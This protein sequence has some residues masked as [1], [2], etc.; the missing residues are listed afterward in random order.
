M[1]V[2]D[3]D[4]E[5]PEE[6][7]AQEPVEPRDHSRL[8][9]VDRKSG[10]ITD[11]HFWEIDKWLFPGDVLVVNDTRVVPAR[12]YGKLATGG[13]V[14]FLLLRQVVLGIWETLARPARKVKP[15]I[16][17]Y[18][19]EYYADVL[20][21]KEEGIRLVQ[22]EPKDIAPLLEARGTVALP[23]YI[24]KSGINPQRYQTVYARKSGAVAAPTAGLHFTPELLKKVCDKGVE[25]VA[26]TLHAGLG[27]FRPVK[28]ERVEEHRMYSEEFE[29]SPASTAVLNRALK[30]KRRVVCVGTTTVRVLE[31]QA[32]RRGE[33][34]RIKPGQGQT[35][36]YIYPGY[37]WKVTGALLT[38]FHL[39]RSTLLMLVCA[40]A[41]KELIITAYQHAIRQRYRFYSFG[42]AMLIV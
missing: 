39:P 24:R 4:Y 18:F 7:I 21:R 35:D 9:V 13:R 10:S 27:T 16:R 6:L 30:E 34:T 26:V 32:E 2:S 8:L 41:S 40:F 36:L 14:E 37:D 11:A 5:L 33:A 42:D 20:E 17:V 29:I 22:F 31:S 38:N 1:L 19:D 23:P 15:G 3:F 12:I 25:V 28:A